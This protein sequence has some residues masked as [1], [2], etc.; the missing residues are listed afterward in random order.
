M[1]N[2][3]ETETLRADWDARGPTPPSINE[4]CTL[5]MVLLHAVQ[6]ISYLWEHLEESSVL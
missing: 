5:S 3:N 4:G 1:A 6:C 2:C